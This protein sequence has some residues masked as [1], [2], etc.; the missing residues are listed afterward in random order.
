M[1]ETEWELKLSRFHSAGKAD[2]RNLVM[3]VH[4]QRG[5]SKKGW[6]NW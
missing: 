4:K 6:S 2:G 1:T 5:V 3:T